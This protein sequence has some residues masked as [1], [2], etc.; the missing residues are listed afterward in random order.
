[1]MHIVAKFL[2]MLSWTVLAAAALLALVVGW[3]YFGYSQTS[4]HPMFSNAETACGWVATLA[5][6]HV[7]TVGRVLFPYLNIWR[8]QYDVMVQVCALTLVAALL[9]QILNKVAEKRR[10]R[11]YGAFAKVRGFRPID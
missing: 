4:C 11:R 2:V 1:M 8:D 5:T 3:L 10:R 6:E 7:M 9:I